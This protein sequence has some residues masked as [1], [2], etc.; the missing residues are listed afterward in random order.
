[1]GCVIGG[2]LWEAGVDVVLIRRSSEQVAAIRSQG[3]ALDGV[4]GAR[5][6][7]PLITT[8]PAEAGSADLVLA[9]TKAYD[10]ESAAAVIEKVLAPTGSVLTMQNGL[11]SHEIL[12]ARFPGRVMVGT[13]TMGALALGGPEFSHTGVGETFIGEAQGPGQARTE[14]TADLLRKMR[15]GPVTVVED[16]MGCVWSKLIINA[17]I[18]APASVLRVKNGD[19]AD[20]PS[21]R[22]LISEVVAECLAVVEALGI[23][24][25]YSDPEERVLAVCRATKG[26]IN[27]ML[28]DILSKRPTEIDF[29]NGAVVR[30]A[31]NTAV[32][33]PLNRT[34]TL[35][36]K[37]I[38]RLQD[39]R[40]P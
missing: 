27:S 13:T 4:S 7:R 5:T 2:L 6:L 28:Q 12:K 26:N 8:D 22:E 35:L 31:E 38:E 24:L 3:I 10:T 34:L 23:R 32:P 36:V 40:L 21:G 18:N 14:A 1:M 19:L 33:A 39:A 30:E 16:P 17:A 25:L 9:L 11:G 37:G 20:A 15:S 29:I